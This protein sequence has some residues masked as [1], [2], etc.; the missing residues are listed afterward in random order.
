MA[1]LKQYK[2]PSESNPDRQYVVSQNM[3]E[4]EWACS[5]TGWTR[6]VPRRDCKHIRYVKLTGCAEVDPVVMA[7]EKANHRKGLG[8]L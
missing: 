7:V 8:E 3:N 2:V 1:W 4:E 5:C 6:H